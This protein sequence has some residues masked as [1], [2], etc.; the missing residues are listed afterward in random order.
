[1]EYTTLFKNALVYTIVMNNVRKI[2][3]GHDGSVSLLLLA[4]VVASS[5]A[6][7]LEHAVEGLQKTIHDNASLAAL[8]SLTAF[9]AGLGSNIVVQFTSQ[10]VAETVN[11][12]LASTTVLWSF[13]G[14]LLSIM[15]VYIMNKI[16]AGAAFSCVSEEM[17]RMISIGGK[18]VTARLS[19]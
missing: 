3:E 19:N 16:A 18:P 4:F 14:A 7:K 12:S 1:M 6:L 13:S 10:L 17:Q 5:L 2:M 11:R 9:V 8:A 15:L